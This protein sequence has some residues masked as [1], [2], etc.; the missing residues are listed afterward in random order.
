MTDINSKLVNNPQIQSG[1]QPVSPTLVTSTAFEYESGS[2]LEEV[3]AGK[4]FGHVYSR[5]GNPTLV[6]LEKKISELE[7]GIGAVSAASGMAAI[8]G[9]VLTLAHA[10]DE[11]VASSSLFGGTYELFSEVLPDY[12]I[13][14]RFVDPG[15]P[16]NF[17]EAINS[18][19]RLLFVETIGNPRLDVV[20][21]DTVGTISREENLPLIVDS[22][23]TTP[24]LVRPEEYGAALVV[25]STTKYINGHGNAVGGVVVDTGNY[26]WEK[27]PHL[28]QNSKE[29]GQ[30]AFIATMR[31]RMYRNFGI[32]MA[33]FNAYLTLTGL[34]SLGA[35]MKL[36]CSNTLQLASSLRNNSKLKK[37]RYP[38]LDNHEQHQLAGRQ[39]RNRYGAI[40]T[41]HLKNKKQCFELI[42]NLN[43]AHNLANI[44]DTRTLIIH[45][46]STICRE[47]SADEKKQMGVDETMLRICVGLEDIKDLIADFQEALEKL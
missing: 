26:D 30:F 8:S 44:G 9:A 2:E 20:D 38:G 18:R 13:K 3:F 23:V 24:L 7:N 5:L 36:H 4:K 14:T 32:C 31:K 16:E 25:H 6:T 43:I 22:T 29:F 40:M 37:V 47:A 42:D 12:G 34:E 21:L 1:G 45:P 46:E 15:K 27:N 35:R 19:T 10:G 39:F 33:P 28:A 17:R 11:I 41:L